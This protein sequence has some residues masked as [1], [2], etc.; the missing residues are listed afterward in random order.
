LGSSTS[1]ARD[2]SKEKRAVQEHRKAHYR[3]E[4]IAQCYNLQGILLVY[5]SL[6]PVPAQCNKARVNKIDQIFLFK[7][8]VL[9]L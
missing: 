2:T 7:T 3:R 6:L 9:V 4:K 1:S 5:I 8:V